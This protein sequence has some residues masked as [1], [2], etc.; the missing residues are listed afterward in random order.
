MQTKDV[1]FLGKCHDCKKELKVIAW[2]D[3]KGNITNTDNGVLY[4]ANGEY[5]LKC[6]ECFNK[7]ETL[8]N[9]QS[10]KVYSRVVGYLRPTGDWNSGK[11]QEFN[12]RKTFNINK[13]LE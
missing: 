12:E 6:N 2:V 1:E 3:E 13:F 7:N 8:E 9:F 11:E 5:F 4:F 10:C